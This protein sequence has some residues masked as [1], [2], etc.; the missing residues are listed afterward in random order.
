MRSDYA[1]KE[2]AAQYNPHS[3]G[4]GGKPTYLIRSRPYRPCYRRY[5]A[6]SDYSRHYPLQL[7]QISGYG[8][9]TMVRAA[10]LPNVAETQK[11]FQKIKVNL[12][13]V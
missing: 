11:A 2:E 1:A 10:Y 5:Q 3:A 8:H 13:E 9:G 7:F 4:K 12:D 6:V